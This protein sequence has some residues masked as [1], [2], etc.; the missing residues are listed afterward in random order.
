MPRTEGVSSRTRERCILFKPSP[1]SVAR[2]DLWRPIGLPICVTR[3]LPLAGEDMMLTR[4]FD[5]LFTPEN[6]AYLFAALGR[7]VARRH[8][9]LEPIEGRLDHIV[10]V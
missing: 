7:N 5:G 2:C 9:T 6:F 8:A 4:L 10:W 1:I 3:I